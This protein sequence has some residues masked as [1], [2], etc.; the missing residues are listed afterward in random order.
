MVYDDDG[1]KRYSN[2]LGRGHSLFSVQ[3]LFFKTYFFFVVR[4]ITLLGKCIEVMDFLFIDSL[5][6][7]D[8]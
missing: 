1:T 2:A 8:R 7:S 5:K 3:Y 6:Y 4:T